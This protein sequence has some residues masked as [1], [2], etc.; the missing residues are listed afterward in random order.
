MSRTESG[1]HFEF[2]Q[3]PLSLEPIKNFNGK[4][5]DLD[6]LPKK[7][8][9]LKVDFSRNPAGIFKLK[10]DS[11]SERHGP[12]IGHIN[13]KSPAN[14]TLTAIVWSKPDELWLE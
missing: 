14:L 2:S 5:F 8:F 4:I 13:L 10:V 12:S 6:F 9:F 3:S 11:D 7:D 1:C